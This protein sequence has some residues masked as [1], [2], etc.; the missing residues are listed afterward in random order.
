MEFWFEYLIIKIYRVAIRN[1]L[2]LFPS[3]M[4]LLRITLLY[5]RIIEIIY[6]NEPFSKWL[7]QLYRIS[8]KLDEW[9]LVK[10]I[11]LNN[12]NVKWSYFQVS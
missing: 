2:I 8:P 7:Q 10:I 9:L 1:W 4:F 6:L 12:W 3:R 11:Y 5:V